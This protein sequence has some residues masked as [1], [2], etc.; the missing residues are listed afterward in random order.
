M[1]RKKVIDCCTEA[2]WQQFIALGGNRVE[3]M[4]Q[5]YR[6]MGAAQVQM[7]GKEEGRDSKNEQEQGKASSW[8]CQRQ[9]GAMK[10]LQ[11]VVWSLIFLGFGVHLV[12]VEE[13]GIQVQQRVSEKNLY[14]TLQVDFPRMKMLRLSDL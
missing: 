12:N 10:A 5:R 6:E 2:L 4:F 11:R 9:A 3:A 8:R 13:Q 1:L 7:P 14:Q